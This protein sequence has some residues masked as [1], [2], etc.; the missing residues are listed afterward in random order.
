[1]KKLIVAILLFGGFLSAQGLRVLE[2]SDMI[3][4]QSS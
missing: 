1:M 4:K 3:N 2:K